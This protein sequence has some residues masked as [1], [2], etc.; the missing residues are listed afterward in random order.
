MEEIARQTY[1]NREPRRRI[2]AALPNTAP[3]DAR[4]VTPARF[5]NGSVDESC[6]A[7]I[8]E[9]GAIAMAGVDAEADSRNVEAA[10]GLRLEQQCIAAEA[11]TLSVLVP[12]LLWA[13]CALSGTAL[14]R[15]ALSPRALFGG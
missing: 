3:S 13:T 1:E 11:P 10:R 8:N 9:T 15:I 7:S 5:V 12:L 4:F 6:P 14:S 2:A